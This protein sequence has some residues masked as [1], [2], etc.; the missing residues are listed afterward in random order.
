MELA[1]PGSSVRHASVARHVT[2]CATR[3]GI[4]YSKTCVKQPLSKTEK[5]V[6][7][8]NYC[9]SD[10][11]IG[12]PGIVSKIGISSNFNVYMGPALPS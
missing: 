2:D 10:S 6:F 12:Y 3:P 7:K 8:T 4:D 9:L 5:L 1:T 11:V